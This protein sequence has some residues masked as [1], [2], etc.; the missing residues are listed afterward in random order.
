MS[1]CLWCFR[2]HLRDPRKR[3]AAHPRLFDREP[4]RVHGDGHRHWHRIGAQRRCRARLRAYHLQGVAADVRR[5]GAVQDWQAQMHRPWR[6]FTHYAGIT[7]ICGIVGA[8]SISSFPLTSGFV[9]KSMIS[10]RLT[11]GQHLELAV[12]PARRGLCRRF[13]PR[14]HQIS[15]VRFFPER[16]RRC[17]RAIRHG[18]CARRWCHSQC[19]ASP[20]A[21]HRGRFTPYCRSRS[22]TCRTHPPTLY[23]TFNCCCSPGSAFFLMLGWLRAGLDDHPRRGLGLPAAW[24]GGRSAA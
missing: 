4:G 11:A 22:I 12:V 9:T 13:S 2:D 20:S 17:G 21:S 19:C 3:H 16:F 23:F 10:P 15:L 14:R 8:L 24:A 6:P 5:V 1:G 18:I 7:A